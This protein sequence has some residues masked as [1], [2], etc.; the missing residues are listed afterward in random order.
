MDDEVVL[1]AQEYADCERVDWVFKPKT[2]GDYLAQTSLWLGRVTGA[3]VALQM[4]SAFAAGLLEFVP[5]VSILGTI[6]E[7]VWFLGFALLHL[8]PLFAVPAVIGLLAGCVALFLPSAQ[9]KAKR[10]RALKGI[11]FGTIAFLWSLFVLIVLAPAIY[12]AF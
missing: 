5:Y 10:T 11:V 9:Q 7:F 4:L 8:S 2:L 6:L 1:P 3:W 12:Q